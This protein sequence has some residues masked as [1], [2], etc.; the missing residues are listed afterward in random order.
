MIRPL[1][2]GSSALP[3]YPALVDRTIRLLTEE[4]P[5]KRR[6]YL[7][8]EVFEVGERLRLEVVTGERY[9]LPKFARIKLKGPKLGQVSPKQERS[10][11]IQI[12][13]N[14]KKS[15]KIKKKHK[16]TKTPQGGGW[17]PRSPCKSIIACSRVDVSR[18][19]N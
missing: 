14:K 8:L 13:K 10:K 18:T 4:N 6:V 19:H 7:D 1:R 15:N 2:G 17:W 11:K 9:Y 16:I 12:S 3:D 5:S